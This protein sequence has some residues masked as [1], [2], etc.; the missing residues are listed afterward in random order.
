MPAEAHGDEHDVVVVTLVP[1]GSSE[2]RKQ[3][4]PDLVGD[5]EQPPCHPWGPRHPWPPVAARVVSSSPPPHPHTLLV[6][7]GL[8]AQEMFLS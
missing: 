7:E 5:A 6:S 3:H 1:F 4:E 8:F 2:R